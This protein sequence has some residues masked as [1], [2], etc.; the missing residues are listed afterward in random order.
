LRVFFHDPVAGVG[1]HPFSHVARRKAN[2]HC[3][4]GPEG[5]RGG[6]AALYGAGDSSDTSF[7]TLGVRASLQASER[8]RLRGMLGWRHAFGGCPPFTLTGVPLAKNV[9]VLEAGVETQLCPN[10]ALGAS[11]SGQFGDGL[12]DHGF[13]LN[14]NWSF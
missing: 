9:A 5:E 11:Y 13:K 3:H 6:L 7:S 2:G 10:L 1:H 12:E 4:H 8:T 14:L